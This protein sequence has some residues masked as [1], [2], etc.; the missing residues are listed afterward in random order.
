MFNATS[1]SEPDVH[2]KTSKKSNECFL[3]QQD[4]LRIKA[5][6][7]NREN[8]TENDLLVV[9]VQSHAKP[10]LNSTKRIISHQIC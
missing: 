4:E 2:H 8:D 5:G 6:F 1:T 7:S 3:T 9:I 10:C